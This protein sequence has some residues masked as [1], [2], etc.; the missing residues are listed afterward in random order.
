MKQMFDGLADS[1]KTGLNGRKVYHPVSSPLSFYAITDGLA[2]TLAVVE[3]PTVSVVWTAPDDTNPAGFYTAFKQ[4]SAPVQVLFTD[5]A[6]RQ[7]DSGNTPEATIQAYITR[8]GR[9]LVPNP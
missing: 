7:L 3:H 8:D 4:S 6:V 9:E 1:L 2:N 5:G